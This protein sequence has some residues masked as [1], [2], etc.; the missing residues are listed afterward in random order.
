MEREPHL[1][2]VT[3]VV[4]K[5]WQCNVTNIFHSWAPW[6]GHTYLAWG[7]SRLSGWSMTKIPLN[8]YSTSI[9]CFQLSHKQLP[10][11]STYLKGYFLRCLIPGFNNNILNC[12]LLQTGVV[13]CHECRSCEK[14]IS[15]K[16]LNVFS[17]RVSTKARDMCLCLKCLLL[18]EDGFLLFLWAAYRAA[19]DCWGK[20]TFA[21][22]SP[23]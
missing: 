20:L 14:E 7:Q 3:H 4:I 13:K 18:P 23:G 10:E 15:R 5:Y 6:V 19:V 8:H 1:R 22:V 21:L 16:N 2:V 17:V 12:G 11:I 9:S